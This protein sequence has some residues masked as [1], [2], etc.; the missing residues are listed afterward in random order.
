M[1][2]IAD[3]FMASMAA[4]GKLEATCVPTPGLD[5]CLVNVFLDQDRVPMLV[6]LHVGINEDEDAVNSF[7]IKVFSRF[8]VACHRSICFMGFDN[9]PRELFDIP[10]VSEKAKRLLWDGHGQ[11]RSFVRLLCWS[12]FDTPTHTVP[13]AFKA[14]RE[15]LGVPGQA[16][17]FP[18]ILFLANLA[19]GI[20]P[21]IENTPDGMCWVTRTAECFEHAVQRTIFGQPGKSQLD[22]GEIARLFAGC[23]LSDQ[24]SRGAP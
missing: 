2:T 1:G 10:E 6:L 5:D 16:H 22:A 19:A 18:G 17:G 21:R 14:W 12:D 7:A 3:R 20:K 23:G 15:S 8:P 9:D 13:P 4:G 24:F 11:V